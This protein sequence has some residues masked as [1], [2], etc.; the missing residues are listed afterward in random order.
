M[1]YTYQQIADELG[2]SRQ[3][4]YEIEKKALMKIKRILA[5]RGMFKEH[6]L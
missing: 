2:I 3:A 1:K 4:V 6:F 5:K